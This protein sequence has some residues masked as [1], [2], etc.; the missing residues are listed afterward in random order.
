MNGKAVIKRIGAI[1]G[2]V[3]KD[4]MFWYCLIIAGAVLSIATKSSFLYPL[5]D[6]VDSNCFYTVGKSMVHGKVPYRDIYEQKGPL[7]YIIH[8]F[9]YL[10]T[11]HTFTGVYVFEVFAAT[12]FLYCSYQ[13]LKKDCG[14][15]AAIA[16]PFLAVLVYTAP[17]FSYGDSAEEFCVPLYAVC[18]MFSFNALQED[19]PVSRLGLFAAGVAGACVLWIKY[20]MLGF[21]VG[22]FI[23]PAVIAFRKGGWKQ[24]FSSIG[25]VLAGVLAASAPILIY[26]GVHGA[27]DDLFQ[28]YF[29]D[30]MFLYADVEVSETQTLWEKLKTIWDEAWRSTKLTF[31]RN[32]QYAILTQIGLVWIL[33]KEKWSMKFHL[34]FIM[35]LTSLTVYGGGRGYIYYGFIYGVFPFMGLMPI[36]WL[37]GKVK[38]KERVVKVVAGI[39]CFAAV[40]AVPEL[41]GS[42]SENTY[43]MKYEKEDLPQYQFAEIINQKEDATLLNYGFLDGGFYTAAEIVPDTRFFCYLNIPLPDV[44]NTQRQLVADGAVD[45]VVTRTNQ[46]RSENYECVAEATFF[47]AGKDYNYYLYQLIED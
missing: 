17:S 14:W 47:F 20:T 25:W 33:L 5:N 23:V 8:A 30:N 27:L 26:F 40:L 44:M 18:M 37:L 24:V 11:P 34:L 13:V 9:G 15:A 10:L 3:V 35:V 42:L 12:I 1:A 6:W 7:L 41:T 4:K 32:E 19:K 46:L 39:C 45:F 2:A 36:C 21:F 22:W 28:V 16:L 38:L 29:Y 43:L 31:K